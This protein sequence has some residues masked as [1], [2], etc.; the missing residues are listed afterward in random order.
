MTV[1]QSSKMMETLTRCK[2]YPG[3]DPIQLAERITTLAAIGR[4]DNGGINRFSYTKEEHEAKNLFKVW[5]SEAGLKVSEDSVGNVFAR[6]EGTEPLLPV[7]LTGSHIDTVPNG[8]A[9]DGALGAISSLMAIESL[10]KE[11]KRPRR[12]IELVVFVDEEGT[13][14]NNALFG[15]RT[16]MGEVSYKDL[17]PIKDGDGT[18]LTQAMREA[19]LNPEEI[20][21]AYYL[22]EKIHAFLELHIEQGKQLELGRYDIGVVN[23]IAGTEWHT[24]TFHGETDHAGNTPMFLRKDSV[25]AAA[26]FINEIENIPP[27]ISDTAV[28]TV[29]RVKVDPNGAN[30]IAGRTTVTVDAR[31]IDK[32]QRD[33]M[34]A[35]INEAARSIA[36]KR[37]LTLDHKREFSITPVKVPEIIQ[38]TIRET[39]DS[40]EL[41]SCSISSGAGHD[42]MI[43]GKYVPA[44]MIFLPSVDGKSHCPEEFTNLY[45]CLNGVAVLKE[46]LFKLA[47]Q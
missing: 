45:D 7:I 38:Q 44:G 19:G 34:T 28:A 27:T 15:S 26:E 3:L 40:L 23:G 20:E 47:N 10:K 24:Y 43:L 42:A 21:S 17:L 41:S 32:I 2:E 30:V 46:A 25:A 33:T 16:M 22:K 31:D 12:S 18:Q 9:F 1:L 8:G 35:R 29:G 11:G 36:K 14:F 4:T 5:A 39:A 6:Y 37:G 13:R